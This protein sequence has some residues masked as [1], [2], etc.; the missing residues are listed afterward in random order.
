MG[1]FSK[2][3]NAYI[4]KTKKNTKAVFTETAAEIFS[5]IV[6][7]TPVDVD[8]TDHKGQTKANWQ[9][10]TD[11]PGNQVLNT[12]DTDG[13]VTKDRELPKLSNAD[14]VV[15]IYHNEPHINQLEFGLYP[16]PGGPKTDKGYSTQAPKGMVRVT[17][18]EFK[19]IFTKVVNSKKGK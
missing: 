6:D 16:K 13:Q 15:Y 17:L 1:K 18:S 7:R 12:S 3:I 11:K 4:L 19:N 2:S 5:R 8:Q 9:I 14:D 10:S